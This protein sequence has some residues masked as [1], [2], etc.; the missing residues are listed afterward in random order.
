M[1]VPKHFAE[2]ETG[3]LAEVIR[4]ASFASLITSKDGVPLGTHL[5]LYLDADN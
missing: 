1:Y 2:T 3:V 4:S 5:P